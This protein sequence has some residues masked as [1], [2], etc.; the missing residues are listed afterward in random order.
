MLRAVRTGSYKDTGCKQEDAKMEPMFVAS[1]CKSYKLTK[2]G[3][4]VSIDF[5]PK[6]TDMLC[7]FVSFVSAGAAAKQSK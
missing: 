4:L 2:K 3:E 6:A 5:S 7:V 1:C